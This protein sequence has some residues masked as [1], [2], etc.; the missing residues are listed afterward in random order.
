MTG[1]QE[2]ICLVDAKTQEI[3]QTI[4]IDGIPLDLAASN[5]R[6]YVSTDKGDIL[7]FNGDRNTNAVDRVWLDLPGHLSPYGPK[8]EI[9]AAAQV[10][11]TAFVS[12]R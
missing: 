4:P 8:A 7:C 12:F 1:G 6:L 5:G 3:L 9:A 11:R 2:G 10:M